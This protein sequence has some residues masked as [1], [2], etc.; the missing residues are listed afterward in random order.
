MNKHKRTILILALA[1]TIVGGAFAAKRSA[2]NGSIQQQ[3]RLKA[4][5]KAL[6]EGKTLTEVVDH[7]RKSWNS[8]TADQRG[9]ISRHVS[10]FLRKSHAEQLELL[11]HYETLIEMTAERRTA[12]RQRARWVKIV[13]GK[14]TPAEA[15]ELRNMTP[16]DRAEKL[17]TLRDEL[18][19]RG[20]LKL[21]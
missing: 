1:A 21:E 12:Y 3:L 15:E 6:S 13:V 8:L 18:V 10:A 17:L 19:D 9:A 20:E 14:L 4:E 5:L 2:K 7:N 11:R 16:R